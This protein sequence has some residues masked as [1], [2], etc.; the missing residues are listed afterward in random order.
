I[1]R[2]AVT[3]GLPAA[4]VLRSLDVLASQLTAAPS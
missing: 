4:L 1:A 2:L 3:Q